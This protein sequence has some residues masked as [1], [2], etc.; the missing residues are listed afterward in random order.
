MQFAGVSLFEQIP[1]MINAASNCF[2]T[3]HWPVI[4]APGDLWWQEGIHCASGGVVEYEEVSLF[5]FSKKIKN[6]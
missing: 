3:S 6:K 2:E 5:R 4:A 1:T